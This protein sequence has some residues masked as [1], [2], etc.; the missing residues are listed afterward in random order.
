MKRIRTPSQYAI[1]AAI[2]VSLGSGHATVHRTAR[3]FG[4]S[5]RSLQRRLAEFGTSYSEL[6]AEVRLDTA[7]DLLVESDHRIA[8]IAAQLGFAGTSSFSRTFQRLMKI[9]PGA[10]RKLQ[11]ALRYS[12]HQN[13]MRRNGR[14]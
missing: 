2:G 4:I 13:E 3:A 14:R 7:C 11:S 12:P 6:L 10:Y 8:D 5:S 1:R 9:Q